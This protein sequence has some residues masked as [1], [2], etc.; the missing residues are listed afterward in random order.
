MVIGLSLKYN[1]ELPLGAMDLLGHESASVRKKNLY[2]RSRYL[3]WWMVNGRNLTEETCAKY[4]DRILMKGLA[5]W[6]D[7]LLRNNIQLPQVYITRFAVIRLESLVIPAF[8]SSLRGV[9]TNYRC[10]Q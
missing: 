8:W 1:F 2:P 6:G 4:V 10:L 9:W 7:N 5:T 3:Y